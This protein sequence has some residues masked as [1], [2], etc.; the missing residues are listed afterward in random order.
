MMT[1]IKIMM[2]MM[3]MM[4]MMIHCRVPGVGRMVTTSSVSAPQISATQP[5][6]ETA[7]LIVAKVTS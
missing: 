7:I 6:G 5:Q 4:M 1:M 3:M 2:I